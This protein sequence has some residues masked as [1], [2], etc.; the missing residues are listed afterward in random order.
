MI[1]ALIIT[2]IIALQTTPVL[3]TNNLFIERDVECVYI[4]EQ[5]K[6]VFYGF[7]YEGWKE[8]T[9]AILDEICV[10]VQEILFN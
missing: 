1:K 5:G 9:P 6:E 3:A 4:D 10:E 8:P 2:A 7:T